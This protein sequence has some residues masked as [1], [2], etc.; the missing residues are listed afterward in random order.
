MDSK[1]SIGN[2]NSSISYSSGLKRKFSY[3]SSSS[4]VPTKRPNLHSTPKP[5]I[6]TTPKNVSST[7]SNPNERPMPKDIQQQRKQLPVYAV[8]DS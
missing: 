3:S 1:Y 5:S 4:N 6:A 7:T 2:K 8:K